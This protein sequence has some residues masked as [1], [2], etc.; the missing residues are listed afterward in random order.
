MSH[1]PHAPSP[2]PADSPP[3]PSTGGVAL[4]VKI[5]VIGG[6]LLAIMQGSFVASAAG[7]GRVWPA[8]DSAKANLPPFEAK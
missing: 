3:L 7:F 8:A 1:D 6:A 5:L 2:T 4:G